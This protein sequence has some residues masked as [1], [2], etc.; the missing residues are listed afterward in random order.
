MTELRTALDVGQAVAVALIWYSREAVF[1]ILL[2]IDGKTNTRTRTR[3]HEHKHTY[4]YN[5]K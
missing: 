2:V 5:V 4:I 3:T 1:W